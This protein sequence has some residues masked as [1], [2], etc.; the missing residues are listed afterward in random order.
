VLE[1]WKREPDLAGVRDRLDDLPAA[2][3]E[4]WRNLWAAVDRALAAARPTAK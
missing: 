4:A 2:E 3:H 1:R